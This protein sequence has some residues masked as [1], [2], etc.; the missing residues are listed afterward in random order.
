MA[1]AANFNYS[2]LRKKVR[3]MAAKSSGKSGTGLPKNTSAALSYVLGPVTGVVFYVLEKDPYV[4]FHAMQ[5]IVVF[6]T[7][8]VLQWVVGITIILLP[9]VPLISILSFVLWLLL[10]YK[11]WMGNEWE[12]PVL[13]AYAR[14]FTKKVDNK[15]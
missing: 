6:V 2:C 4:R 8:F 11:A 15:I 5:S 3:T 10:I 14:K 1:R 13:G 9:I 12:V 7:L